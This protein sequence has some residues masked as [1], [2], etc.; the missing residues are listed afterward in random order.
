MPVVQTWVVGRGNLE[1]GI[2]V[3][4]QLEGWTDPGTPARGFS[5]LTS[6]SCVSQPIGCGDSAQAVQSSPPVLPTPPKCPNSWRSEEARGSGVAAPQ[7]AVLPEG[8]AHC[9]VE[10]AQGGRGCPGQEHRELTWLSCWLSSGCV[11]FMTASGED[12]TRWPL[13]LGC[14][15]I[16][17]GRSP[18]R[19]SD[20][21]KPH[22]IRC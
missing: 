4:H 18:E 22:R 7:T 21:T 14:P 13:L 9:G 20:V 6:V 3:G 2:A 19:V 8:K 1:E 17:H 5:P 15:E 12:R 11:S 16:S 10:H